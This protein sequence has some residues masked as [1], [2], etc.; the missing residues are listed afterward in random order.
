MLATA[1]PTLIR[2]RQQAGGV[3]SVVSTDLKRLLRA[4]VQRFLI[5]D[6]KSFVRGGLVV[7]SQRR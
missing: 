7:L 3:L 1:T 4:E 2:E 5:V 6:I